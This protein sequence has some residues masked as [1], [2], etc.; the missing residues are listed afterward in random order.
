MIDPELKAAWSHWDIEADVHIEV[1]VT[2]GL[3]KIEVSG[4]TIPDGGADDTLSIDLKPEQVRSL[5]D[6]LNELLR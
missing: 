6:F 1:T 3:V 2:G 5:C 4:E